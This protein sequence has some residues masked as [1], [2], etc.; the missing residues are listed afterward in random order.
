MNVIEMTWT[1][2]RTVIEN[3]DFIDMRQSRLWIL[4]VIALES[5]LPGTAS[6]DAVPLPA[7]APPWTAPAGGAARWIATPA[8]PTIGPAPRFDPSDP[9]QCL[10]AAIYYE[11]AAEPRAGREAVAQVVLNRMRHSGYPKTVCDVVFQGSE[12]RTGCQFT[13]TCDGSL[14]RVPTPRLWAEANTIARDALAG[15]V[16]TGLETALNYHADYVRP[17]WRTGLLRLGQIGAHVFYAPRGTAAS[18]LP[19][20]DAAPRAA[21]F[22]VWGIRIATV[23]SGG[24]VTPAPPAAM[25]GPLSR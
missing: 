9:E 14:A 1:S 18:P 10:T 24:T 8:A 6:A 23:R 4:L 13:F 11:A 19:G 20:R 15:A 2:R 7:I 22:A 25:Q 5:V 12:R 3:I 16:A 21:E 17:G